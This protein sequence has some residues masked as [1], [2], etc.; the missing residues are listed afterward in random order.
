MPVIITN[1]SNNYGP[2][3]H[4]EKLI[5]KIISNIF[6]N[7]SLPIYAKGK[8]SREW[9]HV[10][11]HCEALFTLY[12]KGKDG[13]SYNVG[14]GINLDNIKLIKNILKICKSMK[15]KIGNS[16]KIKFVKDR[17]GHDLRY[18]LDNRKIFKNLN[19]KE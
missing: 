4:P 14:S 6:N 13:E 8:N 17:P 12:L 9:I 2:N 5:P 18:A 16:T 7:K 1:C 10:S 19:T 11:D 15:I 3:Q